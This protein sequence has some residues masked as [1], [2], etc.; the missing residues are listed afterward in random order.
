V[1]RAGP[2]R[3]GPL[4]GSAPDTTTMPPPTDGGTGWPSGHVDQ[5]DGADALE[6]VGAGEE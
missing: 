1:T 2:T 6:G 5:G 4:A 3:T